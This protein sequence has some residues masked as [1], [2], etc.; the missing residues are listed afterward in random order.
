MA[1]RSA[2]NAEA[3][4]ALRTDIGRMREDMASLTRHLYGAADEAADDVRQRLRDSYRQA[5]ETAR[6]TGAAA[7]ERIDRGR[8]SLES[9]IHDRPLSVVGIAFGIGVLL[10]RLLGR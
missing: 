3:I 10:G 8:S 4:E 9:E 7:R 2:E 1:D 5:G 6:S